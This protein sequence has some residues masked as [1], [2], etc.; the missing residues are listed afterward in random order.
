MTL[1]VDVI[2]NQ[3]DQFVN[4]NEM[5]HESHHFIER[6]LPMLMHLT[7]CEGLNSVINN[8]EELWSLERFEKRKLEEI[9]SYQR[10]NEGKEISLRKMRKRVDFIGKH[11]WL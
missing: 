5:V 4:L 6:S 11:L 7:L 2:K 3:M 9:Y 10:N 8:K 1:K